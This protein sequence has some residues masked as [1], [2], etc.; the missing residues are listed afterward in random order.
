MAATIKVCSKCKIEKKINLF[1]KYKRNKDGLLGHCKQC[2]SE[3]FKNYYEKHIDKEN[4]RVNIWRK[5]NRGIANKYDKKDRENLSSAYIAK[6]VGL[7]VKVCPQELIKLKRIQILI[8][9]ELRSQKN[10]QRN[11]QN[12]QY[13]RVTA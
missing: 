12:N 10:E 7:S 4:A 13:D 1:G 5:E 8:G 3:Y 11:K 6:T 9:R 2:N